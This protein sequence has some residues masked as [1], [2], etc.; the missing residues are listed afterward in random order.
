M[1]QRAES[2]TKKLSAVGSSDDL[3]V[4]D[5]TEEKRRRMRRGQSAP[6]IG[7]LMRRSFRALLAS[8]TPSSVTVLLL[9]VLAA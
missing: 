4:V 1:Q 6:F 3:R 7:S 2:R 9:V 8:L 5:L